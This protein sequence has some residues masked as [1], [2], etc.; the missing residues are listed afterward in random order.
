MLARIA[1][2]CALL[3]TILGGGLIASEQ[4]WATSPD[5]ALTLQSYTITYAPPSRDASV[6]TCD[7]F[8]GQYDGGECG[9]VQL[10]ATLAG[11]SGRGITAQQ[12]DAG[13]FDGWIKVSQVFGCETASGQRLTDDTREVT[14]TYRL[15]TPRGMPISLP[16]SADTA[17]VDAYFFFSYSHFA[18]PAGSTGYVCRATARET[19]FSLTSNSPYFPSASYRAPGVFPWVGHELAP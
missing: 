8:A 15:D 16:G 1:V 4:A 7:Y 19:T 17:S 9:Y 11:F 6:D 13:L 12:D 3:V 5:T 2:A 18:C 10:I 14:G